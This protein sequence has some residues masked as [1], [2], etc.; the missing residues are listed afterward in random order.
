MRRRVGERVREIGGGI[1]GNF[2]ELT[3]KVLVF[4]ACLRVARILICQIGKIYYIETKKII[5]LFYKL[6]IHITLK[7]Y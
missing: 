1:F 6:E 5:F 4:R 3:V 7:Y 2:F